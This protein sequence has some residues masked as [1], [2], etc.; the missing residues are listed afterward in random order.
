M[1]QDKEIRC[2][3]CGGKVD[4]VN[5]PKTVYANG[6]ASEWGKPTLMCIECGRVLAFD[7]DIPTL[8]EL[9]RET[10]LRRKKKG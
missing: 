6:R 8:E 3:Y 10:D 1:S 4:W 2:R 9:Q 5:L 7:P